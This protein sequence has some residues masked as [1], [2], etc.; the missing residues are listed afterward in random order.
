MTPIATATA[1]PSL[2]TGAQSAL[3]RLARS[4]H[5]R[6]WPWFTLA[7][8]SAVAVTAVRTGVLS[9]QLSYTTALRGGFSARAL[10]QGRWGTVFTSQLLTR[11]IF[12]ASSICLSLLVMLGAYELLAGTRRAAVVALV[13][14]TAG[15][16]AVA[17]VIGVGSALGSTWLGRTMST[18]DFGASAITAGAGGAAVG[19]IRRRWLNVGAAVFVLGGL[20]LH[21]QFADWEHL[22]SASVGLLLG[23]TLGR[24]PAAQPLSSRM[25]QAVLVAGRAIGAAAI[26]LLAVAVSTVAVPGPGRITVA[27]ASTRIG[28]GGSEAGAPGL[29]NP[30]GNDAPTD[31]IAPINLSPAQ[32]IDDRYP[33]PA[34]GGTRRVIVVLPPGY[35]QQSHRRYPVVEL[36]HG[37]PG[38]P[39]DV[40]TGLG[41]P[42]LQ[43][44]GALP[45]FIGVAPDGNGPAVSAGDWADS[46]R[47]H[48]GTSVAFDLR[49]WVDSTFRSDGTWSVMGLSSGGYG[50]AYLGAAFPGSYD[51]VC[52][53]SG[54]YR[55]R[56]PAFAGASQD[57]TAAA[58]PILRASSGGPRTLVVVGLGDD[59]AVVGDASAYVAALQVAG[60]PVQLLTQPGG[61]EWTLWKSST[62]ACLH[63]LLDNTA[64]AP[65]LTHIT[66]R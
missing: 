26:A 13:C 24:A 50:A 28:S 41:L 64:P 7:I 2:A 25:H 52:S 36:L 21:H 31:N 9:H 56:R 19:L 35:D 17:G 14:G 49:Q 61:H 3:G 23:R 46:P 53:M 47:Q 51:S 38:A 40:V 55:A 63:F 27:G 66:Q 22:V 5:R 18:V 15:P 20:L 42:D 6:G 48:L 62:P 58:S 34:L 60:Q 11:D 16:L 8:A 37:D 29:A 39:E 12:M 1:T 57:M 43:N 33:S 44:S 65:A 45:P 10:Q 54:F 59:R 32:V 30:S 4:P